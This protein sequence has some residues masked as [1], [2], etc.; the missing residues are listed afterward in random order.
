MPTLVYNTGFEH[1]VDTGGATS[2]ANLVS[3][4]VGL[5]SSQ[6]SSAVPLGGAARTGSYGLTLFASA[7]TVFP[8]SIAQYGGS[9]Q[10]AVVR[11]YMNIVTMPTG[12]APIEVL[13]TNSM[14]IRLTT[15]GVLELRGG[16][17]GGSAIDTGPTLSTDVWYRVEV[18]VDASGTTHTLAWSVDGTDEGTGLTITGQ[19]ATAQT[20]VK[21]G[22][23][24]GNP[25]TGQISI[26]DVAVSA[27]SG[28][29][30]LGA[31]YGAI[32]VPDELT[33]GSGTYVRDASSTAI[34]TSDWARLDDIPMSET[35]SYIRNTGGTSAPPKAG[36]TNTSPDTINGVRAIAAYSAAGTQASNVRIAAVVNNGIWTYLHGSS[37]TQPSVGSTSTCYACVQ[38]LTSGGT[39][40]TD[41]LL[42]A[43]HIEFGTG[44]GSDVNPVPR[45]NNFALEVDYVAA[46][47]GH[48][49]HYHRRPIPI[50]QA[51]R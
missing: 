34:D 51:V 35:S 4:Q 13:G 21:Y 14:K 10:V 43:T 31:G 23:G 32:L 30:P 11:F 17:S 46:P 12:S 1:G 44:D 20:F 28:D 22:G 16:T 29:Y 41:T 9:A 19:A 33:L 49:H 18:R 36:F 24:G 8:T 27:T 40:W 26:D 25:V 3:P 45:Y 47:P 5:F 48:Q 37:S 6:G 42:D 38:V 39:P 7:A 2:S 15:A 50:F